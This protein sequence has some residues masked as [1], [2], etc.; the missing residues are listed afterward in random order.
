MWREIAFLILFYKHLLEESKCI[1]IYLL[2]YFKFKSYKIT[3]FLI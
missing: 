3:F 1:I 2:L